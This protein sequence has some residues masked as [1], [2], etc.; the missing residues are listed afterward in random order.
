VRWYAAR[1][2]R[3]ASFIENLQTAEDYYSRTVL[4]NFMRLIRL[5]ALFFSLFLP[6]LFLAI[7]T[8]PTR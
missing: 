2:Y 7:A 8:F 1:N 6:G 3:A 4:G 5:T